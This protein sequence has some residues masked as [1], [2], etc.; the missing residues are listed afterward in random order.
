MADL[1][2]HLGELRGLLVV[3]NRDRLKSAVN[4][5]NQII[6]LKAFTLTLAYAWK[7]F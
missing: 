6:Y 1:A 5:N 3:R 4:L 2:A 7:V